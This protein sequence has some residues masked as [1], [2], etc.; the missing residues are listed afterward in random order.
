MHVLGRLYQMVD[1]GRSACTV[2][3][4]RL[5]RPYGTISYSAGLAT[6]RLFADRPEHPEEVLPEYF[7]DVGPGIPVA[8]ERFRESGK[9]GYVFQPGCDLLDAVEV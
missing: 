2:E 3:G 9:A 4:E 5:S 1:S 6:G 8:E 7:S